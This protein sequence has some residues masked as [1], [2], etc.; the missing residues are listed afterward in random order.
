MLAWI[1]SNKVLLLGIGFFLS[2][3]LSLIPGIKAN[4]VIQMIFGW[5]KS[6]YDAVNAPATPPPAA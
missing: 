4:G 3:A 2:E 6:A 1:M 5:I